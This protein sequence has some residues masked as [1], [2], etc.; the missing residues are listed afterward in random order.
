M[1]DAIASKSTIVSIT[2]SNINYWLITVKG[3]REGGRGRSRGRREGR[4]EGEEG[5]RKGEREGEME[6]GTEGKSQTISLADLYLAEW[7]G[8]R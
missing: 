7:K 8:G 1:Y 5:G 2:T 3:G 4:R 6:G